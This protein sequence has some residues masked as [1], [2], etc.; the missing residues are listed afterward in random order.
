MGCAA[1]NDSQ[2]DPGSVEF[3]DTQAQS[4]RQFTKAQEAPTNAAQQFG[5]QFE[6]TTPMLVMPFS[7]FKK[8]GRIMKSTK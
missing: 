7:M 2:P 6:Q 8:Q 1:S 5:Q 4:E 3:V